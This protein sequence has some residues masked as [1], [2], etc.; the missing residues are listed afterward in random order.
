MLN[1]H[2]GHLPVTA[3]DL[4]LTALEFYAES[5]LLLEEQHSYATSAGVSTQAMS[6]KL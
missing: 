2:M 6:T 4:R 3:L 1:C 5:G